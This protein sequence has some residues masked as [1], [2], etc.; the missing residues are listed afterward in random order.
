MS[1][2]EE[3]FAIA[4]HLETHA[5]VKIQSMIRMLENYES[6]IK[7]INPEEGG[8]TIEFSVVHGQ[9]DELDT[10][11]RIKHIQRNGNILEA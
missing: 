1:L 4:T 7:L 3:N 5:A 10:C 2:L 9:L 6:R 8:R 11:C